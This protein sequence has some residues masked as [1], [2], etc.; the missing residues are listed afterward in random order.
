MENNTCSICNKK[1]GILTN[2]G[3]CMTCHNQFE[4]T[5]E[6]EHFEERLKK[7]ET[8]NNEQNINKKT[9]ACCNQVKGLIDQNGFCNSCSKKMKEMLDN[10][11]NFQNNNFN[12]KSKICSICHAE[13]NNVAFIDMQGICRSCKMEIIEKEIENNKIKKEIVRTPVLKQDTISNKK[14]QEIR[15]DIENQKDE[16]EE[17]KNNLPLVTYKFN[18][19]TGEEK[20]TSVGFEEE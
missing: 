2:S 13:S 17:L 16:I 7:L 9:C 3:K 14:A 6:S 4:R 15:L 8:I 18:F 5:N 19:K 12:E 20:Q 11:N 10:S 1:T